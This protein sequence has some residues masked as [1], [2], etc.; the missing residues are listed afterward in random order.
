MDFFFDKHSSQNF[1]FTKICPQI[2]LKSSE[3]WINRKK[4]KTEKLSKEN[5]I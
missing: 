3:I 4:K 1:R 2:S 5:Y